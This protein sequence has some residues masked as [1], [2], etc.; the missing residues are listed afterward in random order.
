MPFWT[1]EQCGAQFPDSAEPPAACL[2][3]TDER[4]YVNWKSQSWIGREERTRNNA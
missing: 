1:C 2:I 4:Q 3:C